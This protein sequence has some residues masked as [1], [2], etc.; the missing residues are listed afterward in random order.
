MSPPFLPPERRRTEFVGVRFSRME[1]VKLYAL[2]RLTR[3]DVSDFIRGMTLGSFRY[4]ET[5]DSA[6]SHE[7]GGEPRKRLRA[8]THAP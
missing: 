2:A 4:S 3:M 7:N 6:D 1:L 8:G 5:P